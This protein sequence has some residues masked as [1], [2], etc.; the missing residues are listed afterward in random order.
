[1]FSTHYV[2]VAYAPVTCFCDQPL[3]DIRNGLGKWK[4][5]GTEVIFFAG[6]YVDII[7]NEPPLGIKVIDASADRHPYIEAIYGK[8]SVLTTAVYHFAATIHWALTALIFENRWEELGGRIETLGLVSGEDPEN[9]HVILSPH[10]QW[11]DGFT[12]EDYIHIVTRLLNRQITIQ[13][14]GEQV[15]PTEHILVEEQSLFKE[16]VLPSSSEE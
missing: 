10:T 11:N 1:M 16:S 5:E 4:E 15:P 12:Q 6:G 9:N 2:K 13:K 8:G 14:G 3:K 7:E